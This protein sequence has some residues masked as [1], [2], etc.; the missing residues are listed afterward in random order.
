[1]S[2]VTGRFFAARPE[3]A[4]GQLGIANSGYQ[5][6]P[7]ELLLTAS[8]RDASRLARAGPDGFA[9]HLRP[10]EQARRYLAS[11]QFCGSCHD[12]RLFG[13]DVLGASQ[14][15]EH[16]KRLRNAYTEWSEWAAGERA[17]GR[18][19]ASCQDCHMSTFPG[20]CEVGE[21]P[22]ADPIH[23]NCP[24]GTAFVPHAPGRRASGR[25]ASNS[26]TVA[27]ISP[28]YFSGVDLP[29]AR[30]IS[31]EALDAPGLDV[32]GVPLSAKK[33]R[34]LLLSRALR[35][36]LDAARRVGSELEVP[37]VVENVW[38]GHKVPAGFSQEREIWVHLRI[39][40]G[41][42]NLVYEVGRVDRNDEDLRDKVFLRVNTDP[43]RVDGV[44]R[45]VGLFGA[46]V[47][48]GADVP[49]WSPPPELGGSSFRGRGLINFQN[50]FLRCV[51]CLGEVSPTGE[52]LPRGFERHRAERFADGDYDIDT[53][54]CRSNL[55]GRNA[56]L[57]IYFPVGS[58]DADRGF[59][60]GP[61]AI[62]DTRSL[63]PNRPVRYTYQ[64]PVSGRQGPF[65]VTARLMFRSFPP[66]L[67]RSFAE[68]EAKQAAGGRRPSGPLVTFEMLQ[69]LERVELARRELVVP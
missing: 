66:F 27:A 8:V 62:I 14:R 63:S 35:L 65:S 40:D 49:R 13:S 3:D 51:R 20:A 47:R 59:V 46:D 17:A 30:E 29:L 21:R 28:H 16:F 56:L 43:D 23:D 32:H 57:E 12:V 33:R 41:R 5:L 67:V 48:D 68:Y 1:V 69:R 24:D 7:T 34:N 6:D 55:F 25:V 37:V 61:D 39:T 42:G 31:D 45:P 64:L 60:K 38:G 44:G 26:P 4:R 2:F 9:S 53:G 50:G 54:E 10:S 15:G 22:N 19:P 18:T 52:C 36:E 58:L 11:S